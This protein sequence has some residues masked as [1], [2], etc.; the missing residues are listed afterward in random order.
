[1]CLCAPAFSQNQGMQAARKFVV[2]NAQTQQGVEQVEVKVFAKEGLRWKGL[3]NQDGRIDVLTRKGVERIVFSH[4]SYTDKVLALDLATDFRQ[5]DTVFLDPGMELREARI[6]GSIRA[7][8][9]SPASVTN[10]SKQ[11]IEHQNFGQDVPVLLNKTPSTVVNSDAGGGVG[12]TG[13]RIRGVDPTRINVTINGVPVND[14]ESHGLYW[15]NMPDFASSVNSMQIQ[16]GVGT[17]TNGSSAFGASINIKTDHIA[18][19]AFGKIDLGGGSYNTQRA[20]VQMG[21]GVLPSSWGF[22]GRLSIIK[23][24]GFIDRASSN[25]KSAFI[26][27]AHYGKGVLKFNVML[28]QEETYQAWYGIP[29][30]KFEQDETGLNTFMD[31]L[32]ILGDDRKNLEESEFNTYNHY[33][34]DN[35]VDHYNQNHFQAF[36][37]RTINNKIDVTGGLH[38]T[39]GEGYY[40]QLKSGQ[41]LSE[42]GINP[43]IFTNDTV[44]H[45][46]LIRRLWLDNNF[47][48]FVGSVHTKKKKNDFTL[49]GAFS[50]YEGKHF[51][52][53]VWIDFASNADKGHRFYE[54]DAKK[55]EGNIYGK[56]DVQ[57][58]PSLLGYLDLQLRT[59]D[60]TFEGYARNGNVTDQEV[61]F[62]FFNPKIGLASHK[63]NQRIFIYLGRSNREPVRDDFTTSTPDSRPNA[64]TLNNLEAGWEK[65]NKKSAY[66]VNLYVMH[67]Q[68]QLVLTGK[69]NDVGAYTRTNVDQSYRAGL[70]LTGSVALHKKLELSANATL[71]RNKII[72]FEEFVDD[73]TTGVQQV[74][75]LKNLD[76]AFSPNAIGYLALN[77]KINKN[78]T[79]ESITKGVGKQ[80]LDNSQ[81]TN[82]M[83][84]AFVVSGLQSN[85]GWILN[86]TELNFGIQINN[87]L[88]ANYAPNGYTFGAMD[89]EVRKSYNYVYPMA[90]RN[91]LLRATVLF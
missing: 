33:T 11:E 39:H 77:Y 3:T 5:G 31:E 57:L 69:I 17:S 22:Q 13:I 47:Y 10:L 36:Y 61:N 86:Q 73:W 24:E 76:L 75:K 25:L 71:S 80:Y 19:E 34:Y 90:T 1:M 82:R 78:W 26:T 37:S 9:G 53:V 55:V 18:K 43:I 68:N 40:E 4:I 52:E 15:V 14:A 65:T 29:Q 63:N 56:W 51:G 48:G 58:K 70:E 54:N 64:E 20:S 62:L 91:V 23:S 87:V 72:D 7:A 35:E 2:C 21:T 30:P 84:P 67:Y 45:S 32:Y 16:R 6:V 49:G 88:N 81:S 74:N 28:G 83:L 60:Y 50:V 89:G 46:D 27:A 8:V 59:V 79:L 12:Y 42:Y 44:S 85:Y 41:E 66:G 38:Y